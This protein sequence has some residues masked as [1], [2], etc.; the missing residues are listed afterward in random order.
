MTSVHQ[1]YDGRIFEKE[2]KS[3]VQNGYDVYLIVN[4]D[5][6]DEINHDVKIISTNF[7]PK[8]RL[9]RFLHSN[10]HM[11]EQALKVDAEIYHFHDP[12]LLYVGNK[13]KK[14]G[15]KVIFDSH[16]NFPLQLQEK[17]YIPKLFR[18]IIANCYTLYETFSVK[19]M[20]AVIFPCT[21]NS[22]NPFKNRVSKTI[23]LDN[24]PLLNEFYDQYDEDVVKQENTVCH[25]GSLNPNRGITDII[26]AAYKARACLILGGAF[27]S[28]TYFNQV[29]RMPEFS[30]VD[31]RGFISRDEV[32]KVYGHSKIG[33]C[34][35]LNV[36]QYNKSDN[37]ATKVYEYM[38]MGLPVI[39]SDSPYAR[40]VMK[41]YKFGITVNPANTQEIVNTISY[42][43]KHPKIAREMGKCGRLAIKEK[44]NWSIEEQK[45]IALYN[46][47]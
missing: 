5:L 38:S 9:D 44:F 20:D 42:L 10:K 3:L 24:F 33:L 21:Y 2:C 31:Y 26:E 14:W 6:S 7:K 1:R 45:L 30:C 17:Q 41:T 13:L 12:E 19:R 15:K 16:E 28:E 46:S 47:L 34:T 32:L 4:D 27:S 43:L 23:L 36:G 39:L 35:L 18:N 11:F 25:I 29:R 37:F 22:I 40:E 8:N